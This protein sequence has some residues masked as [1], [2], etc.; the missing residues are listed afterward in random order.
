M[1]EQQRTEL[2]AS[3]HQKVLVK[4]KTFSDALKKIEDSEKLAFLYKASDMVI[5][6]TLSAKECDFAC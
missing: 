3:K 1:T 5:S 4:T 6:Q 2:N